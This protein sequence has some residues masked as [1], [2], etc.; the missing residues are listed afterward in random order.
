MT[1]LPATAAEP[2]IA[3]VSTPPGTGGIA[4]IRISGMGALQI[5][6]AVFAPANTAISFGTFP[7]ARAVLGA[8]HTPEGELVDEGLLIFFQAPRSYTAEDVVEISCH[9][10][11]VNTRRVL[12]L[13]LA[14]GARPAGPGEF[15]RRAY[16]NGRMDITQAE[17]VADLIHARTE[18]ASRAAARQLRGS[19]ARKTAHIR[20]ELMR[21]LAHIEAHI[22]FPDE[23]ITPDTRSKLRG[24]MDTAAQFAR[25]IIRTSRHGRILRE[26]IRT[27]IVGEPN[28]GKSSLFNL[29]LGEDRAIITPVAGTTRDTIEETLSIEGIP[30]ALV[31][32]AGLRHTEDI[33]EAEG[34]R[35]SQ[36][37]RDQAEL[38]LEI[39]DASRVGAGSP[40]PPPPG[41][42]RI[43]RVWNKADLLPPEFPR[44]QFA[45]GDVLISALT[46]AGLEDLHRAVL[47]KIGF[48]GMES[49]G[50]EFLINARVR[51]CLSRA[52]TALDHAVAGF[53]ANAGLELVAF[54]LRTACAAIGE[55]AGKT[56]TDDLLDL[57]FSAFCIG[58]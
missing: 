48:S 9:G 27:A 31:D 39:L 34:I 6:R 56:S 19:L 55:V 28:V 43:L 26:G 30:L 15:T 1:A 45:P 53:D 58:K 12:E 4:V 22:D 20:D 5:A 35:R 54:D 32:T 37:A 14:A 49:G 44:A 10:G 7:V 42:P 25:E 41:D 21:A 57:I 17:A 11:M 40:P 46:G 52:A 23:D 16:L 29:L 51:D 24:D 18:R 3:A 2:V 38:I 50:E 36:L 8:I 47:E 13:I 33:V